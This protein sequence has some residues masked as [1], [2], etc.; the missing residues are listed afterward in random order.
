M[1]TGFFVLLLS[2]ICWIWIVLVSVKAKKFR[3]PAEFWFAYIIILLAGSEVPKSV[4]LEA[5]DL[6]EQ[7]PI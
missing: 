1:L 7:I 3:I 2:A 6:L 5:S 4:A